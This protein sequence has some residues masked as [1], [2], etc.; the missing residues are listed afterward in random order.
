MWNSLKLLAESKLPVTAR[1]LA[2]SKLPG[3][4]RCLVNK[5]SNFSTNTDSLSIPEPKEAIMSAI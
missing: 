1:C 3:A 4:A 5:A 2:V